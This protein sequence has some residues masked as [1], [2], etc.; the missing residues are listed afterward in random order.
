MA[1]AISLQK[2]FDSWCP[3]IPNESDENFWR[4]VI[5]LYSFR[6]RVVVSKDIPPRHS[7]FSWIRGMGVTKFDEIFQQEVRLPDSWLLGFPERHISIDEQQKLIKY[8]VDINKKQN[9]V[10][11]QLDIVTQSPYIISDSLSKIVSIIAFKE[12]KK[13]FDQDY[14]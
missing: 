6:L 11:K 13:S 1:Q 12:G 2:V 14:M 8:L 5:E 3:G 7:T 4:D 10:M 9:C